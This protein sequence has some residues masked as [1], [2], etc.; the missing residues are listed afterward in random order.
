MREH[1]PL[2]PVA[3]LPAT[4][5]LCF[6]RLDFCERREAVRSA[7]RLRRDMDIIAAGTL[8]WPPRT[9]APVRLAPPPSLPTPGCGRSYAA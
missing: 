4:L 9:G 2:L 3:L 6:V 1:L 5:L 7:A 8:A